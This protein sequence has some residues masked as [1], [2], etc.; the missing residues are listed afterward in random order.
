MSTLQ[1]PPRHSG[2]A[3]TSR[4]ASPAPDSTWKTRMKATG[5][6]WGKAASERAVKVND[7]VGPKI[8]TFAENKL[9]THAFWPVTGDFAAEM[10][11]AASILREFT[12]S[13]VMT[14]DKKTKRKVLRKVPPSVLKEAKGLAIFTSMRSGIAP[15]GGAGGAGVVVGRLEDGSWSAPASISPQNLSTGFLIGIDVYDCILVIRTQKALESFFGHKVTLGTEIAVAAGPYGAGAGVEAGREA[16]PVFSY[17]KSRGMYAG[18]EVVGQV[19]VSRFDE[20]AEMYHWPGVKAGD[21][22]TGKVK[23]PREAAELQS[24][25]EDAASGRA[26]VSQGNDLDE[27]VD[28]IA[29]TVVLE[30][31]EVL[32]LPPTPVQTTGREYE[33]DPETETVIRRSQPPRLPPRRDGAPPPLPPRHPRLSGDLEPN[34]LGSASVGASPHGSPLIAPPLPPRSNARPQSMVIAPTGLALFTSPA[35]AVGTLEAAAQST[36]LPPSYETAESL[37]PDANAYLA[38]APNALAP[39]SAGA[40]PASNY[41]T[42][43]DDVDHLS[44]SPAPGPARILEPSSAVEQNP[45]VPE[46]EMSES[47]RREWEQH[48][49]AE[50]VKAAAEDK[51]KEERL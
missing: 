29:Q 5:A 41:S 15:I 42:Y 9:G 36:D 35:I 48:W 46:G 43:D 22:L 31:G 18:V 34:L 23:M 39:P 27:P 21:I 38:P 17:V 7:Y 26:Q 50:R 32:K 33:S 37:P 13:G 25:L 20:N 2:S 1:P 16:A 47:E 10:D 14:T 49:E 28:E 3:S 19:F 4:A 24:A 11:K 51:Q 44:L 6:R 30:D 12:V 45:V 40:S 8:N